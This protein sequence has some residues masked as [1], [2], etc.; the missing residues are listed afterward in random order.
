MKTRLLGG[1][2]HIPMRLAWLLFTIV[3]W[4]ITTS[5]MAQESGETDNSSPQAIKYGVR[6][7]LTSSGFYHQDLTQHKHTGSITGVTVG[8]FVTYSPISLLDVS[9]EVLYMQQGGARTQLRNSAV[10]ESPIATTANTYLHNLEVP[11]LLKFNIPGISTTIK[12]QLIVGPALGYNITSIESQDISFQYGDQFA[13]GSGK[14]DVRSDFRSLQYGAYAGAGIEIPMGANE[15]SVDFRYRYG[16]N[17]INNGMDIT[18]LIGDVTDVRTNSYMI[19][20]GMSF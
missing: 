1:M 13:T 5:S 10:D 4:S 17:A 14:E 11:L 15:L 12:P 3:A 20:L 19:T 6:A 16:V 9:L 2:L 18:N 8:G 7:G